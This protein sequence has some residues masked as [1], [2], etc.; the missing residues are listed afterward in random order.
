[1]ARILCFLFIISSS[2]YLYAQSA[3]TI[4]YDGTGLA[5]L[6]AQ[7]K[8]T[9]QKPNLP[10]LSAYLTGAYFVELSLI[11]DPPFVSRAGIS[12]TSRTSKEK[13]VTVYGGAAVEYFFDVNDNFDFISFG[14]VL[15]M[16]VKLKGQLLLNI[17]WGGRL[18]IYKTIDVWYS[19]GGARNETPNTS[20]LPYFPFNIGVSFLL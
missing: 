16:N 18:G 7:V 8:Y 12:I 2:N 19:S 1:M 5:S 17:E 14:P 3:L 6:G 13:D 10:Q 20:L 9:L 11:E 15:G 4:S